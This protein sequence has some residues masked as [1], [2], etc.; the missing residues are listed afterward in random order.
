MNLL[1]KI[2]LLVTALLLGMFLLERAAIINTGYLEMPMPATTHPDDDDVEVTDPD[3]EEEQA[4]IRIIGGYKAIQVDDEV[5][6]ITGLEYAK[7]SPITFQPEFKAYAEVMDISPLVKTRSEYINTQSEIRV[8]ENDL[9]NLNL[10]LRRAEALHESRSLSTRELEKH[11]A[12]RDLKAAELAA[13]RTRLE[14][15]VYDIESTWGEAISQ[16]VLDQ[17]RKDEF[18]LLAA[19]RNVL[20]QISLT[21]N[22][23]LAGTGQAVY[24]S[25][26]NDRSTAIEAAYVDRAN[27]VSNPLY[28]ESHV[29]LA[30]S[31]EFRPGTRLFAWIAEQ[32]ERLSGLFIPAS[33][34]IWYAND[35]WIYVRHDERIFIRK[36]LAHARQLDK[37][38]IVTE[39]LDTSDT[40]VVH[41]GQ[42]LLS[43][44][45]KWAI[46]DEDDD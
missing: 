8:L 39:G 28:S 11:R 10:I 42:T 35:P 7:P 31:A 25:N 14:N 36:P 9:H 13:L 38:W 4:R 33:A 44:E 43:E 22:Q 16:L 5:I 2:L 18:D 37:G 27:R 3:E 41:G 20:V 23:A 45:F 46:P 12:D 30:K 15:L 1:F 17:E 19:H 40:V 29:Y 32:G 21:K 6:A 26:R 34:V 24:V